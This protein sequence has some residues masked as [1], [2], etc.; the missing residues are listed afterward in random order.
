MR[1]GCSGLRALKVVLTLPISGQGARGG[2]GCQAL[3]TSGPTF[4]LLMPSATGVQQ[5]GYDALSLR[6][7]TTIHRKSYLQGKPAAGEECGKLAGKSIDNG[8]GAGFG[9][10]HRAVARLLAIPSRVGGNVR[11]PV[12]SETL[13]SFAL[14]GSGL[15]SES[16]ASGAGFSLAPFEEDSSGQL[17][18]RSVVLYTHCKQT[19][20]GDKT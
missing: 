17:T 20:G 19:Q 1:G 16:G 2:A 3:K 4:L 13:A 12:A 5:L 7:A 18:T 10:A 15:T 11:C 9:G 6:R 8:A 14:F